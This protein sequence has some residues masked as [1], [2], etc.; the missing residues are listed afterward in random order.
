MARNAKQVAGNNSNNSN[1]QAP[2]LTPG[3]YPARVVGVVFLGVQEQQPY[4][5]QAKDPVD[6]V[7]LTYELSS[8]FMQDEN[9]KT[10]ED[11]PRWFSEEMPFYSLNADRAKSTRRYLAIDPSDTCDGDFDKLLGKA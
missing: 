2:D 11:K 5:G 6:M 4:Q 3:A 1:L 9:G 7:R 10:L 8:E